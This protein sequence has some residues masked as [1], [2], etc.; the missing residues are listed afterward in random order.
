MLPVTIAA[1]QPHGYA[2]FGVLA[3]L[4]ISRCHT[5]HNQY[6]RPA[7][8]DVKKRDRMKHL[9]EIADSAGAEL[10]FL[11]QGKHEVSSLGG[12]QLYIPRHREI[13]RGVATTIM[14]RARRSLR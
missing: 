14:E 4:Q 1:G 2:G 3:G 11:R 9:R 12:E 13:S 6:I 5:T 8:K 10:V 7:L